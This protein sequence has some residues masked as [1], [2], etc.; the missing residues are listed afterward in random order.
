MQ[1]V[2]NEVTTGDGSP[3]VLD[4]PAGTYLISNTIL[5]PSGSYLDASGVTLEAAADWQRPVP[6]GLPLGYTMIANADYA[7]GTISDAD[8]QIRNVS[9]DW[10]GFDN[11]GSAAVRFVDAEN[12]LV[13]GCSFAGGEDGT[14][15]IGCDGA[16]VNGCTAVN[17]VNYSYDNWDG[18]TNTVVENSTAD[19]AAFAGI[20]F[21][22][23][24]TMATD[25]AVASNDAAIGNTII[26]ADFTGINVEAL[27][28]NSSA[29][30]I[31][32]GGNT[33]AG[34][35]SGVVITG[36]GTGEL[37]AG[38]TL[39]GS[40]GNPEIEV[41][42]PGFAAPSG[43]GWQ[44][45]DATIAGNTITNA[46][47]GSGNAAIMLEAQD[48]GIFDNTVLF[49]SAQWDVWDA[50][51]TVESAG[52]TLDNWLVAAARTL[53]A[54]NVNDTDGPGSQTAP[55]SAQMPY[56]IAAGTLTVSGPGVLDLR[57]NSDYATVHAV[58]VQEGSGEVVYLGV[59]SG[60][61]LAAA[62]HT[63]GAGG[64]G[65]GGAGA[66][67]GLTIF[68]AAAADDIELGAGDDV[69]VL[70]GAQ[71]TARGG[72][73][74]DTFYIDAATAGATIDGGSGASQ[75]VVTGGGSVTLGADITHITTVKMLTGALGPVLRLNAQ[76]GLTAIASNFGATIIAGAPGQTLVAGPNNDMLTGV[77]GG[78]I[79]FAGRA[80]ELAT[81]TIDGFVLSDTV[82]VTSVGT[83]DARFGV[84]VN[85][86]TSTLAVGDGH[87]GMDLVIAG[88]LDATR[89]HLQPDASVGVLAV[90]SFGTYTAGSAADLQHV[91]S[92]IDAGGSDAAPGKAYT[93]FLGG[94]LLPAATV[95]LTAVLAPV[96]LDPGASLLFD[97][98]GETIDAGGYEGVAVN[99]GRLE[100][101]NLALAGSGSVNIGSA[102][103]LELDA[104]M[105]APVGFTGS[106]GKLRL[107][108]PSGYGG[109][110]ENPAGN[111]VE[112]AGVNAASG[113]IHAGM[114]KVTITGGGT[115]SF[116]VVG[117]ARVVSVSENDGNAEIAIACFVAGTR[118]AT[119]CG[120]VPVEMLHIGDEVITASGCVERIRWIGRRRYSAAAVAAD[121]ARRPIRIAAGALGADLPRRNLFVSP[122]HALLLDDSEVGKVLV[123]AV[124][125]VNTISIAYHDDCGD[126]A[127]IHLELAAHDAVLAEGQPA[128]TF[129]DRNSRRTFSNAAE[130][131][132]IYPDALAAIMPFCAPRIES[133][134]V[135]ARIRAVIE[136]RDGLP[137]QP[138]QGR[139][140]SLDPYSAATAG[141]RSPYP[142]KRRS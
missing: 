26:G 51:S 1:A 77:A 9:F 13:Q 63:G 127:Y 18:P 69:V 24:G 98:A 75:L 5:L 85:A 121:R 49:G 81:T 120:E 66:A 14:A 19:V 65:Y 105:A 72:G 37:V 7:S 109:T 138:A 64:I 130:Y 107:D 86:D 95:A 92:E 36:P 131:A 132:R 3:A 125:L 8:I 126:V 134:P 96:N 122:Q 94:L 27:S 106:G 46:T 139:A 6:P 23:R 71:E 39:S 88:S 34:P 33:V 21:T 101:R 56:T 60:V 55:P 80:A 79:T 82:D 54:T 90:Y 2:A 103:T 48:A 136:T 137:R 15:F 133:G 99:A 119:P 38:N 17:T 97:G 16:V 78:N 108:Q 61:T 117:V 11:H 31:F 83:L 74:N 59:G 28:S 29:N 68:G 135:L 43:A 124:Q 84:E 140:G 45:Q 110:I 25:D 118:I 10:N 102:A 114:L 40:M 58:A 32:I 142:T 35:G 30:D 123:P 67:N 104:G 4:I 12:I 115:L 73:G 41:S 111:T 57:A 47:I 141:A 53:W 100:L 76:P 89:F 52:N 50:G 91:L 22:A 116:P 20:A 87:D 93:L 129:V 112:L 113:T 128:E 44:V 62:S 70:G 42:N